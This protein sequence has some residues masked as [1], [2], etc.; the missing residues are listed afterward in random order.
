MSATTMPRRTGALP[1]PGPDALPLQLRAEP[2][3]G[4]WKFIERDG[5]RVKFPIDANPGPNQ[6]RGAKAND[7]A[8]WCDFET[9]YRYAQRHGHGLWFFLRFPYVGIDAD[10]CR[11]PDTGQLTPVAASVF[12][13]LDTYAEVSV[14]GTGIKAIGYGRKP[15][16]RCR[17]AGLQLELYDQL[18]GFALTGQRFEDSPLA[19]TDCQA[20]LD[21]IYGAAFGEQEA[22]RPAVP[23]PAP[24]AD[25]DDRAIVDWLHEHR[26]SSF[27]SLWH[28]NAGDDRSAA[29]LAL[30]NLLAW[31][32]GDEHRTDRLFRQSG[33]MR[34]K[35][36]ERR[37]AQTYGQRTVAKAF[38][39]RSSFWTPSQRREVPPA[40]TVAASPRLAELEAENA[41]LRVELARA[42]KTLTSVIQIRRNPH[43]KAERDTLMATIFDVM[44]ER[45]DG[46]ADPDGWVRFHTQR[47]AEA[48]GKAPATV[49]NHAKLGADNN[50]WELDLRNGADPATGERRTYYLIRPKDEPEKLLDVLVTLEP[51]RIDKKTGEEKEGWGGKRTPCP[52]CG[53]TKRRTVVTC[54]DCGHEFSN[55]VKDVAIEQP[56]DAE[57][58]TYPHAVPVELVEVELSDDDDPLPLAEA[59]WHPGCTATVRPSRRRDRKPQYCDLHGP[60]NDTKRQG[61]SPNVNDTE[62]VPPCT[63]VPSEVARPVVQPGTASDSVTV[64]FVD[65]EPFDWAS[66]PITDLHGSGAAC[67]RCGGAMFARPGRPLLCAPCNRLREIEAT[68]VGYADAAGGG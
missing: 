10:D 7:P 67:F 3:W 21:H 65:T 2:T 23:R 25:E 36:D 37:G 4:A 61:L 46:H 59:C 29:D 22:P 48:T 50:L 12:G 16:T 32:T 45:S 35:W 30:C 60:D 28:G 52:D 64:T 15:G 41:A 33:L 8:T 5:Q 14:S 47:I 1:L 68:I 57:G 62:P 63:T 40:A 39:G 20:A 54:D 58:W 44:A 11:D 34:D 53:S 56:E 27:S 19:I 43:I 6:G 18:R 31:R 24:I 9:A 66:V 26:P 42:R 17:R 13:E 38:E 49:R 51:T 55:T